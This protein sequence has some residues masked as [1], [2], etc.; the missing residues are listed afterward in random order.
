MFLPAQLCWPQ[1]TPQCVLAKVC[2]SV[3]TYSKIAAEVEDKQI[4]DSLLVFFYALSNTVFDAMVGPLNV[5]A[6]I[7]SHRSLLLELPAPPGQTGS[8]F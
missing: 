6:C 7:T 3:L 5:L 2:R 8:C 1:L 4:R